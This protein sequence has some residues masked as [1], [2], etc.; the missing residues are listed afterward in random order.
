[1]IILDELDDA[2]SEEMETWTVPGICTASPAIV[3][4]LLTSDIVNC[5]ATQSA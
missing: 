2:T 3:T 1:M 5:I 4:E